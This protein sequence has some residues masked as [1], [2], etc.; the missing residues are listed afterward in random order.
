MY[1]EN[2]RRY[3]IT[4]SNCQLIEIVSLFMPQLHLLQAEHIPDFPPVEQALTDPDGLLAIGGMLTTEWL[5]CAY[6]RGIF[7][8]YSEGEPILW[9]SPAPRMVLKPGLAH[10][11]KSLRKQ[12]RKAPVEIKVNSE[13]TTVIQH[14]ANNPLRQEGTWITDDMINAYCRLN[15]EGWAHCF[16]VWQQNKLV[17]GLYGIGMG[18]VFFGESMFSLTPGASKF[19]FIA[20]SEWAKAADLTMI[21][22]QL[23]NPYLDSLGAKLIDRPE[24]KRLLPEH[25]RQLNL[26]ESESERINQLFQSKLNN[27]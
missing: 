27:R 25:Q 26:P 9:W 13:F 5:L 2:S 4:H 23:Y 6:Q 10:I 18:R 1:E 3:K 17:G 11:A 22:C 7:P 24:F 8:W 19:A 21:D 20:L 16:E 14:C 15:R 12:F